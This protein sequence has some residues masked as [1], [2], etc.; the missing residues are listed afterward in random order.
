LFFDSANNLWIGSEYAGLAKVE[1][2]ASG[3][4]I[5]RIT[6]YRADGNK[7]LLLDNRVYSVVEDEMGTIWV[8]TA[9]GLV[10]IDKKGKT[11][12]FGQN[13]GLPD[14]YITKVL[15]DKRGYIWI[16]HKLGISRL[17]I[18]TGNIRNYTIKE[19]TPNFEFTDATGVKDDKSGEMFLGSTEGFVSFWPQQIKDNPKIPRV[20]FT[21][22]I[23]QNKPIIL[24]EQVNGRI[25][26]QNPIALTK[27]LTFTYDDHSFSIEFAALE[28]IAPQRIRYAYQLKRFDNEWVMTDAK[29]RVAS[30]SNLPAGR[31]QLIVKSTNSDGIWCSKPTV[32]QIRILPPWWHTWWAY[33]GYLIMI[34]L[35]FLGIFKIIKTRQEY[36]KKLFEAKLRTEKL[37]K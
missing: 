34:V 1:R 3:L 16:G 23:V 12:I 37:L 20:Y 22:I 28:Y 32:L 29:Q 35:L 36:S 9:N 17:R 2:D 5:N 4:N 30:Y 8:G 31:Y 14:T 33:I 26:L 19:N 15:A 6:S 27:E 24:G 13:E 21:D 7:P 25:L 11:R 10:C 18:S